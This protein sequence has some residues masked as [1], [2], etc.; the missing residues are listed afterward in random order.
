MGLKTFI[1]LILVFYF[2]KST[3]IL[4]PIMAGIGFF[5]VWTGVFLDNKF[6]S[7]EARIS[8]LEDKLD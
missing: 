1:V 2:L 7:I 4:S 6:K 5:T 3:G 8:Y